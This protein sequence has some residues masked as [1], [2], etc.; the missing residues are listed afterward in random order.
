V[1]ARREKKRRNKN[2]LRLRIILATLLLSFSFS[3]SALPGW[4]C[5]G[6]ACSPSAPPPAPP[7][8]IRLRLL[9]PAAPDRV[10]SSSS[11]YIP[12]SSSSRS[13]WVVSER[14][15]LGRESLNE[16]DELEGGS[17]GRVADEIIWT[18]R[19]GGRRCTG[20][21]KARGS[22]EKEIKSLSFLVEGKKVNECD[23]FPLS[24]RDSA[25]EVR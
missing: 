4:S 15:R 7:C 23:S 19:E 25:S 14:R 21:R 12:S 6:E 3:V 22:E 17:C 9:L 13:H 11:S 18:C 5:F 24:N 20:S 2:A 16:E 8:E 10:C 1:K